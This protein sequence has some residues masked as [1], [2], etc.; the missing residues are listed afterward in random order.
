MSEPVDRRQVQRACAPDHVGRRG[1]V[2]GKFLPPHRGHLHLIETAARAVDELIVVVG[3]LD[4]EPIPGDLRLTWLRE[5]LP[6]IQV[7]HLDQELPQLPEEHPDFWDLWRESLRAVLG[8]DVDVV[9]ASE[10]YGERLAAE[11]GAHYVPVDPERLLHGV[12]GTMVRADPFACAGYLPAN[13]QAFFDFRICVAGPESTGKTTL[14]RG[15]ASHFGGVFVP[16]YAR[17]FLEAKGRDPTLEDMHVIAAMQRASSQRGSALVGTDRAQMLYV[18]DTDALATVAWSEFL[19]G[20]VDDRV[21]QI[22]TFPGEAPDLTLVLRPDVPWVADPI[23]YAQ[24]R[25][26][27]FFA[28][29]LELLE[30]TQR[31]YLVIEG[32]DWLDREAAAIS[33]VRQLLAIPWEQ[34]DLVARERARRRLTS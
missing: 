31:R 11:L 34:R 22:A 8:Q 2:L 33:A 27:A 5:L 29:T 26:E 17:T 14:A 10:T 6:G 30:Q 23:R 21:H 4:R 9:F 24:H 15:L 19:F 3:S 32:S 20:R 16:E 1:M 18:L 7:V 25:G 13:V 12:S 28:R